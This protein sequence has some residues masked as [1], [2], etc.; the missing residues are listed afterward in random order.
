MESVQSTIQ[1]ERSTRTSAQELPAHYYHSH[2]I[3]MLA[4]LE[5]HYAPVL[6][7]KAAR[8]RQSFLSLSFAAQCLY[9]RL[10]NRRGQVFKLSSL[11]Y[12]EIEPMTAVLQ[13][14]RHAGFVTPPTVTSVPD[15]LKLLTRQEL[16]KALRHHLP[17]IKSTVAKAALMSAA[18]RHLSA[19]QLFDALPIE[20]VIEQ[21][22]F[23]TT[24]FLLFLYFG[25]IQ[26]GLSQFALRDL[27]IMRAKGASDEY[28]PRFTERDDAAA[29]FFFATR[30]HQLQEHPESA[31]T[32]F[33]ELADWPTDIND[34]VGEWR[35]ALAIK[36]GKALE[37]DPDAALQVYQRGGSAACSERS[38]RLLL[39]SGRRDEA[40][41]YLERCIDTPRCDEEALFASDLYQRKFNKKRTSALTDE[42]RASQMI[43]IDDSF[44]GAPEYAAV[45][46]FERQGQRA[47]RAENRLWRMF[48]GL[49]FWDL[50][51]EGPKAGVH[52]PF[53]RVP[54]VVKDGRFLD[55]HQPAIE[56]RLALFNSP[57]A[58]KR[59]LVQISAANYGTANG[60]F[61]WRQSTHEALFALLESAP[62]AALQQQLL[63][64]C[65]NYDTARQGNPDLL[66]VDDAGA[67]FIEIKAPGDQLRRHQL[68]RLEQLRASGLRAEIMRVRYVLD[69][70]QAY[71]VV[72]VETTGGRGEHHRITEIA[73]VKVVNGVVVDRFHS[74]I[75]PQRTIPQGITRLTGINDAMVAEAPLFAD[76]AQPLLQFFEG[77]IFVAHNVEFDYRFVSQEFQRWGHNLRMPK[78]CTCASMRK[79]YPGHKSYGLAALA[80]AFDIPL[81]Q[82]HRAL[83]DAE[84]TAKLLVLINAK[85]EALLAK[86]PDSKRTQSLF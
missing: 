14:L 26:D 70:E 22:H 10:L 17:G 49:M 73:A 78:L 41:A 53:E 23:T 64:F 36:L 52:S 86:A 45:R 47:Y 59:H 28:E 40:K 42:L 39:T 71:T 25:H 43:D 3:E 67:R 81:K 16:Y 4:F 77:A 60:L 27:G 66:V 9:V 79:F 83:C 65:D 19:Q 34:T 1:R 75:N 24:R 85:R 12:P 76:I 21:G 5:V 31:D 72:D 44:R 55:A 38:V 82:H 11:R 61:R 32:L 6:Q 62:P 13:E 63:R 80:D 68:L 7:G 57:S 69:P 84:A 46:W 30:L 35:D 20:G 2:F 18:P 15:L 48:F 56:K 50:L 54:S 8:F 37:H 51:F 29:A 58:V 74:L 33:K